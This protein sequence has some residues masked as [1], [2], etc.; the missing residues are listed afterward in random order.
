MKIAI[1]KVIIYTKKHNVWV[2]KKLYRFGTVENPQIK[3]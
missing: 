1:F 2:G 3:C